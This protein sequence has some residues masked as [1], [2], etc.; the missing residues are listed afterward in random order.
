MDKKKINIAIE[1][2][3]KVHRDMNDCAN[4]FILKD[5]INQL[6]EQV[7]NCSISDVMETPH[8]DEEIDRLE[9][10]KNPITEHVEQLKEYKAIKEALSIHS[11]SKSLQ[12]DIRNKLNP[13]SNLIAMLEDD[14]PKSYMEVEIERAK[15]S[16]KYLSDFR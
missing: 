4:R 13:I 3:Q 10:F 5:A 11:V 12:A 16:V 2:L 14:A 7:K 6:Q 8:L 15:E 9:S 1:Q